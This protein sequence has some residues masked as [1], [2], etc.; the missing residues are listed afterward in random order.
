MRKLFTI[1]FLFFFV[2]S[3][4]QSFQDITPQLGAYWYNT[5]PAIISLPDDYNDSTTKKYPLIIFLHGSGEGSST[6][7]DALLESTGLPQLIAGGQVPKCTVAGTTYKF[8]V[9]CPQMPSGQTIGIYNNSVDWTYFLAWIKNNYRID[10]RRIYVTGLSLG[11]EG[12]EDAAAW[13]P[14]FAQGIT[15]IYPVA[16]T[17]YL[18]QPP[19]GDSA[20]A[21]GKRYGVKLHAV[22]GSA[23][24]ANST[25]AAWNTW[26][27]VNAYNSLSPSPTAFVSRIVGGTHSTTTWNV[28]YDTSFRSNPYNVTGKNMYE[29]FIQYQSA[30]PTDPN[31]GELKG[32]RIPLT[33]DY[34]FQD[35]SQQDR[36]GKLVD[37]DTTVN[38][39][40]ARPIIY[41]Q[42]EV[43]FDLWKWYARVTGVKVWIANSDT[44][45]VQIIL[46][47]RSDGSEIN[48]G[49]FSG[50]SNKHFVYP[51]TD[52]LS[53]ISK[54]ILRTSSSNYELGSEVEIWGYY[55]N[56]PATT[57]KTPVVMGQ[58]SGVVAHPYDLS[59]IQKLRMVES[60][61]LS[62]VR[63]WTNAYDVTDSFNRQLPEPEIGT[64]RYSL[65]SAFG[66]L[67][68]WKPSIYTWR[69]FTGQWK[70][71]LNSWNVIDN[72]PNRYIKGIVQSYT[73]HGSWGETVL[74][75]IQVAQPTEYTITQ[76]YVYKHGAQI[77]WTQTAE[78]FSSS[79]VG[80]N[81]HYNLAGGSLPI[82]VG[83]TL[84]FYKS[85]QSVNPIHW[86]NDDLPNRNTD[87]AFMLN[88]QDAFIYAS[89]GGSNA[90]VPNYTLQPPRFT[91]D[92]QRMLKGW[93][94]YNAIEGFNEADGWWTNWLGFWNGKTMF[95][96]LNMI[97]DGAQKAYSNIGAKQADSTIDVLMGG[98][99]TDQ[100][101]QLFG[102]IEEA[103]KV[104]GYNADSTINVPWTYVN[105]HIY[106][107]S[108]G[109]Y[110]SSTGGL[111]WE[112]GAR[113]Q[114]KRILGLVQRYIPQTKM[115]IS[116]WGWD[117][118]V[119]SPLHAG[120][121]GS[122]DRETVGAFWMVRAMVCMAVDGVARST[123]YTL[124]QDWPES[125]SNVSGSQFATMRLLRQPVDSVDTVITRSRQGDYMAQ[126]NNCL[127]NYT[128]LDSIATPHPYVH[129]YRFTS[130]DT[131]KVIV[132][133]EES[134]AIATGDTLSFTERTG[135][136]SI[137]IPAGYNVK[138]FQDNG[139]AY[140][141]NSSGTSSGTATFTYAAKPIVIEY[142]SPAGG[143][144][145]TFK[146]KIL[147]KGSFIK[148]K[149]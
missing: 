96:A 39:S 107:S 128:F 134:F 108:G 37:G 93:K 111:P 69:A 88:G 60:L 23:D 104:R 125:Q 58:L 87:T 57:N 50:G 127:Y 73:D 25:N 141:A 97:Y 130:G 61:G 1:L 36:A 56:P 80:Q 122:Y 2:H 48:I 113:P 31:T 95:H 120:M 75:V 138:T 114:V 148:R 13:N 135:T 4:G 6:R 42:H 91:G 71:Q 8:I 59:N 112:A 149:H 65:D 38:Y 20:I 106:P 11:A 28:A 18:N 146:G 45:T 117:Q 136:I 79:L 16:F 110:G 15:A 47:K 49:T 17:G 21:I 29:W 34:V 44:C 100:P 22:Y 99:A 105:F 84:Y 3:F 55:Q 121:F 82:S 46:V 102:A 35:N 33:D 131:T 67:K 147:Y 133:S 5:I 145:G 40:P 68:A 77:N 124:F 30:I 83:D 64:P 9:V 103:R 70:P 140:M 43:V 54:V 94:I 85:Q 98:M 81:R 137:N 116:E 19:D 86:W 118:N 62:S 109:Q 24:T 26:Q 51:S 115:M 66:V 89:R 32:G 126:Y 14:S 132:W 52:T 10:P 41:T 76:W 7:N 139:S 12:A 74:N 90:N 143:R 101:D 129:A 53:G 78:F 27:L 123:Y 63:G 72:F 144:S 92:N 119:G 142:Y